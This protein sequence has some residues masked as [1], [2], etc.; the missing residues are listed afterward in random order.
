MTTAEAASRW[1]P[2]VLVSFL[3]SGEYKDLKTTHPL[4]HLESFKIA[5]GCNLGNVLE[6]L[7]TAIT[8]TATPLFTVMELF[9]PD[10]ELYLMRPAHFHFFS[11]LA[12]PQ[13]HL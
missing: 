7:I 5:A 11:C 2:L 1:R 10:T 12:P 4:Q 6:P 8:T 9:H 13:A 3:P